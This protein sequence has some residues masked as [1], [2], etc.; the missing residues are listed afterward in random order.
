MKAI[1][2][3]YDGI[4]FRSKLEARWAALFKSAKLEYVYEPECFELS[5]G[6]KYMPDFYL[7]EF[8]CYFEVKPNNDWVDNKY[9]TDRYEDFDDYLCI[10]SGNYPSNGQF[11]SFFCGGVQLI[12]IDFTNRRFVTSKDDIIKAIKAD[13]PHVSYARNIRFWK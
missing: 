10:L 8:K 12:F 13:R 9:H 3:T 7:P 6:L 11:C 1:E 5:C 4:L 2:T